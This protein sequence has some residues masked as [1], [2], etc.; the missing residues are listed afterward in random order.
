MFRQKRDNFRLYGARFRAL[1]N[2]VDYEEEGV[3]NWQ[4]L[5]IFRGGTPMYNRAPR[6]TEQTISLR[7]FIETY[8]DDTNV[9]DEDLETSFMRYFTT[10][11]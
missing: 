11:Y 5:R 3:A 8:T 9:P 7:R 1:F 6:L 4:D 10:N 2:D